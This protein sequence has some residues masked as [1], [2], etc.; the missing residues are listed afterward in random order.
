MHAEKIDWLIIYEILGYFNEKL[1]LQG[2]LAALQMS[3]ILKGLE[4]KICIL[5]QNTRSSLFN[6]LD[7]W[8]QILNM[9]ILYIFLLS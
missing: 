1:Q 8:I 3:Q 2:I 7:Y 9:W 5:Y 4:L 6:G